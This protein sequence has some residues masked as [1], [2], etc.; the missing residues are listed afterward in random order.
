MSV[1]NTLYLGYEEKITFSDATIEKN[2]YSLNKIVINNLSCYMSGFNLKS[3]KGEVIGLIC[4]NVLRNDKLYC[5]TERNLEKG[6]YY[7]YNENSIIGSTYISTS[8][9][10]ANFIFNKNS[11]SIGRNAIEISSENNYFYMETI[12]KII[13]TDNDGKTETFLLNTFH[14]QENQTFNFNEEMNKINLVIVVHPGKNYNIQLFNEKGSSKIY[15]FISEIDDN[16]IITVSNP[17]YYNSSNIN[18]PRVT[19]SGKMQ[20]LLIKYIIK[21]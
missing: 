20:N 19:I 21:I 1:Y 13:L 15:E 16:I 9:D 4:E 3:E 6:K 18:L 11:L 10:L 14:A 17:Y 5:N 7:V 12:N 8:I 2:T